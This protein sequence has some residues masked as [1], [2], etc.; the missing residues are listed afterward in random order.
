MAESDA[1]C[2]DLRPSQRH[3]LSHTR[4]NHSQRLFGNWFW[5]VVMPDIQCATHNRS[6]RG[7][8]AFHHCAELGRD[9][10]ILPAAVLTQRAY[11]CA[12]GFSDERLV[13]SLKLPI[14]ALLRTAGKS[15]TT[16]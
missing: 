5:Q 14:L 16:S 3:F 7:G 11:R 10:W 6:A 2:R 8:I 1:G 15:Q 12:V 13:V 9:L 4:P